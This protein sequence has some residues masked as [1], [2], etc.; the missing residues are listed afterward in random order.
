M[1]FYQ[2]LCGPQ[3]CDEFAANGIPLQFDYGHLTGEGSVFVAQKVG[4]N[5]RGL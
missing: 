5:I 3:S 4:Q 2:A 1:S